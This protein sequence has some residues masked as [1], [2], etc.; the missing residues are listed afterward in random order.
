ML[1]TA[2]ACYA[3]SFSAV[4]EQVFDGQCEYCIL[5]LENTQDGKLVRFYG[6]IEKYELKIAL[7]CKVTTS[8]TR[9]F[10]IF[11]L[12]RRGI[13]WPSLA[14]RDR[15]VCFE[16]VF[17]QEPEHLSIARLLNAAECSSL[18]L[19][20]ADCLPRSDDEILMGAGYPFDLCFELPPPDAAH[21]STERDFLAFLL[22]LSVHA[23]THLPLGIYQNV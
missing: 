8:D 22:F 3:D 10:T 2:K 16:F 7:T 14:L 13:V 6:L 4:C 23:P 20:R 11:G 5:P 12:C 17:W 21:T 19:L 9:H 18:S 1:P 15:S